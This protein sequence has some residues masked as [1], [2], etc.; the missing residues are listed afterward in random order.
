VVRIRDAKGS[1]KAINIASEAIIALGL[2]FVCYLYAVDRQ[3]NSP[4]SAAGGVLRM[5]ALLFGWLLALAAC[6][7]CY[8]A[9]AMAA[10]AP[11]LRFEH[12]NVEDGLAQETVL[13]IAQDRDGFMWFGTQNGLSR[14][15]GYRFINF[16][17]IIGDPTTLG[18]N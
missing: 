18:S 2:R 15:D 9:P 10:P 4:F 5:R 11:T 13:A 1:Q 17:N 16:R 6:C 7:C 12:L 8:S 14:F 3:P